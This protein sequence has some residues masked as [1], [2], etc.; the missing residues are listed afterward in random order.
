MLRSPWLHYPL[1]LF[2]SLCIVALAQL[3]PDQVAAMGCRNRGLWAIGVALAGGVASLACVFLALVERVKG[4]SSGRLVL[5]AI[6][7]MVPML[8]VLLFA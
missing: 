4:R 5:F 2:F 3:P 8:L 6:L 7:Y 1:A